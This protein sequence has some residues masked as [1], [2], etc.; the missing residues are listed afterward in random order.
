[1]EDDINFNEMLKSASAFVRDDSGGAYEGSLIEHITR[2]AIIAYN[3][4]EKLYDEVKVSTE[5]LIRVCYL[6]Q[7]SR[8]YIITKNDVDWEIKKGKLF[9]FANNTPALKCGEY[10]TFLCSKFGIQLTED[11]FEA[12]LSIDK[13]DDDQNK[14]FSSMLSQVLRTAVELANT[15][16]RLRY[17]NYLK[18]TK[19]EE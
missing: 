9:K 11:E 6:H 14:Y 1:M 5:S 7:I 18:Q 16:R 2:I 13:A 10:S 12:I 19:I 3:I 15:E 4:N 17:K 8:A